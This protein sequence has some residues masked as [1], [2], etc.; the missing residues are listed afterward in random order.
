MML[1]AANQMKVQRPKK[2]K[3]NKDRQSG[4]AGK[5][6]SLSSFGLNSN[7]LDVLNK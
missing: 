2:K 3:H 5:E 1:L 7:N 6:W 4:L